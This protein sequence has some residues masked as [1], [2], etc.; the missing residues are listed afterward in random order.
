MR[1]DIEQRAL[2]AAAV[3]AMLHAAQAMEF[4]LKLDPKRFKGL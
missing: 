4:I 2:T 3:T 1:F